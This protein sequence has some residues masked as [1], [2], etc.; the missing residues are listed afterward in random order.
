MLAN[1]SRH[2]CLSLILNHHLSLHILNSLPCTAQVIART[3]E[4][5]RFLLLADPGSDQLASPLPRPDSQQSGRVEGSYPA[6]LWC[7]VLPAHFLKPPLWNLCFLKLN[8]PFPP[9]ETSTPALPGKPTSLAVYVYVSSQVQTAFTRTVIRFFF[10]NCCVNTYVLYNHL[11][12]Y[13][14]LS[15]FLS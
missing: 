1:F 15:S 14:W 9:L 12:L 10:F 7:P 4:A 5:T 8:W 13:H 6:A 2:L 3:S 11:F